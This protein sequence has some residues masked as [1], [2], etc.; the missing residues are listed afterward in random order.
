VDV[1]RIVCSFVDVGPSAGVGVVVSVAFDVDMGCR[2]RPAGWLRCEK[3]LEEREKWG[4]Y[5]HTTQQLIQ[6]TTQ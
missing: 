1:A 3:G 6:S 2:V 5:Q 4:V